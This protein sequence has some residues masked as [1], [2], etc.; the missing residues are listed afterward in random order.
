MRDWLY[1]EDHARALLTIITRGAV[2]ETYNVGGNNELRNI[3]VVE[4]ICDLLDEMAPDAAPAPAEP[5]HLCRGPSRTRQA[6]RDR[7]SRLMRDLGWAPSE[8]FETGLRKTVEW[9]TAIGRGWKSCA[10]ATTAAG[11]V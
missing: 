8:T 6:L 3:D 10:S 1:V 4:A 2:G 7:R 11:W 5:D 9:Y